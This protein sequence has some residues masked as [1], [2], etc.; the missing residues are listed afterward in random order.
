MEI[1][2]YRGSL[3]DDEG[4]PLLLG[5]G[6]GGVGGTADADAGVSMSR[7]FKLHCDKF[8]WD[9]HFLEISLPHAVS[10]AHVNLRFVFTPSCTT[11]PEIQVFAYTHPFESNPSE[12]HT[13]RILP[14]DF[15]K[16]LP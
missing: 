4:G 14:G 12:V 9:E 13:Y 7:L 15:V 1:D 11:P 8:S 2:G 3:L 6:L 10:V 16:D 5:G